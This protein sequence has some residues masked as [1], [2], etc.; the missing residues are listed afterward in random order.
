[1]RKRR[2]T[3]EAYQRVI[4]KAW[5]GFDSTDTSLIKSA[6]KGVWRKLTG[7]PCPY[8][9]VVNPR[10]RHAWRHYESGHRRGRVYVDGRYV[11]SFNPKQGLQS[12][13]HS[14]THFIHSRLFPNDQPHS[15]RHL[16]ME[17]VAGEYVVKRFR[18]A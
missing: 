10:V 1:M 12:T 13:V 14:V 18:S 2:D 17:R 4:P 8:A 15:A 7:K 5:D 6:I 11:V 16:E 3:R 9:V